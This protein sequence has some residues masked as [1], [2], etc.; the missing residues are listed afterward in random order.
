MPRTA[1]KADVSSTIMGCVIETLPKLI[2]TT[3][4]PRENITSPLPSLTGEDCSRFTT[5]PERKREE[6]AD[7]VAPVSS[8][9]V[10][11]RPE[12]MISKDSVDGEEMKVICSALR[13]LFVCDESSTGLGAGF[14]LRCSLSAFALEKQRFS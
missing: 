13:F 2:G 14:F 7:L 4:V 11:L 8:M 10:N 12:A 6:I 5:S 1:S 3:V 9:Q